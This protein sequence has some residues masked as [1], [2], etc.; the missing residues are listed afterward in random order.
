MTIVSVSLLTPQQITAVAG[1]RGSP[2][3]V[4]DDQS[5]SVI[6]VETE[7]NSCVRAE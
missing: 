2:V 5:R 6:H 4:L 3:S 7:I 1:Q